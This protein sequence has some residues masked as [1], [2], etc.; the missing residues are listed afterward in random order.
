VA[1]RLSLV[2]LAIPGLL[3]ARAV[4]AQPDPDEVVKRHAPP[5]E[6]QLFNAYTAYQKDVSA[7]N[8]MVRDELAKKQA[9]AWRLEV[10]RAGKFDRWSASVIDIQSGGRLILR[11]GEYLDLYEDVPVGSPLYATI[12]T[13]SDKNQAVYISGQITETS[14]ALS[15]G[16]YIDMAAPT[17]FEEGIRDGCEVS[18]TSITA[19]P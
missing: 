17:C 7:P 19:I 9:S 8:S 10:L 3:I 18:L 13:L 5:A 11:L 14:L 1:L 2:A 12:R 15:R 4:S 6:L 16:D